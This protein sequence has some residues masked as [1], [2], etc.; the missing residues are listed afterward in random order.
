MIRALTFAALFLFTHSINAQSLGNAGTIEGTV[1]DPSGALVP[2]AAVTITNSVT[3]YK[4]TVDSGANGAFRLT[5]IPPNGYHLTVTAPGF[6]NFTQDVTIRSSVPVQVKAI[7]PVAAAES[8][9]TV[10]AS[11]AAVVETD[12]SAHVD[13]DRSVFDRLPTSTPGNGL[14]DVI[15]NTSGAIVSD[16]NGSFHPNGDHNQVSYLIDGQLISDQQSKI[17]STSLPT[18]AI[19]SMELITGSPGAEFGDKT[20]LVAQITTRSGLGSGKV[21]GNVDSSYGSFGTAGGGFGLGFGNTKIGN[22]LAVDGLRSG[23]FLDTPEFIPYHD[24]GNN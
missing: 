9:V 6:S 20:S 8:T 10:E 17:F 1:V 13:V 21:F 3:G 7:L 2:K 12:P 19:Q 15:T 16:A 14:A 5:N 24:I 4:Q 23:R 18:S 22:F 11:G